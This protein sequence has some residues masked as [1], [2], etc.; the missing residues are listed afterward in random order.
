ML[1]EWNDTGGDAWEEPVT[2]LVERWCREQ[3]D[4]PAVVDAAGRTLTWG[5]LGE[6]AGRLAAFLRRQGVGRES[7]VAVQ[8]ERTADLLVA[9][10][11]VLKAGAAYLSL[12]PAHPAERLAF[13][14]EETAASVVLTEGS[15]PEI[16]GYEPL[17]PQRVEPDQLAYVLYTSGST[18]RPK[19]VQ[20]PHRGLGNLVRWD[21]RAHGTGPGDHRTQVASL[22][23]DA[24]VLEIWGCLASGATLHLPAEELRLDPPRLAAWMAERG[25]TVA[26]L[27]TPLAEVLLASGGPRIP[28]LR[29]LLVGGDRLRL[30]PEPGCGFALINC[31]GPAEASVVTTATLGSSLTLGRPLG[32]LK[33]H[34]LDRALQ[35]VPLGVAGELWVGGPS[36]ARGYLKDPARTAERFLPDPW[37]GGERLY[38]TGDLCR[39][40]PDGEI[41]FLGRV[42]HQ[43]KIRGQRIELGEIETV[44]AALP[45]VREAVVVARE[46][47]LVAYVTGDAAVDD[48]RRALSERLPDAM[49]PAAF[50]TLETLPLNPN[51]KVDRKAL[52]A[53]ERESA[54][55]TWVAPRTPVEEVVAGLWAELLGVERVGAEGHFFA[56]G[57][58]SLLAARVISRLRQAFGVEL[59]VRDL[60]EAPTVAELAARV[61]AARRTTGPAVPELVPVLREGA[62]P[63]SFAQ[64]R[65]WLLDQLQPGTPLYNLPLLLRVEGPLD[66]AVLERSLGEIV[67]RHE[68]LRT[69][70]AVAGDAPVQVILPPAPFALRRVDLSDL[71]EREAAALALARDEA[72]RPFDLA[73]DLK[74]RGLLVRLGEE[75]HVV[76]LTLHHV[77]SDGWSMGLL[78]REVATLYAAFSERQPSPLPPLP[79]QYAD[80]A[81]WQ[82]SWLHGETLERE[83]GWW[84]QQLA[85]LPPLLD[86]PTDRPRSAVQ[87][88]RGST[89]PV[90]LPAGLVHEIEALGRSSGATLFMVLLAGFEALLGRVS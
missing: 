30:L 85:G 7:I 58:H 12:D 78:V 64:Q 46:E 2:F 36:L 80:F 82:R 32:G 88:V 43:V 15:L 48:L 86:L 39:F 40:R 50:V 41:E 81:V 23:F 29:R 53:P 44:L 59:P 19:G 77:A 69:V 5:A 9:Q 31:Y 26:F 4:A 87:S 84:R 6:R 67:R 16:A 33:V 34:L 52:P 37:G 56:L 62:P 61:E 51:G 18:G 74:L 83:I 79:V 90:R 38:R 57:G 70:F 42:D 17:P 45:G 35:P 68:A 1:A 21:L 11:G 60:F 13:M 25:V 47:R 22:G 54:A 63:L 66:A 71:P 10:L 24:S 20:V 49:V 27:P 55:D 14:R 3:P 76:A 75:D 73:R 8:M 28:T 72:G 89:R 65:L